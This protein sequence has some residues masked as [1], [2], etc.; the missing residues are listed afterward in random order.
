LGHAGASENG[1][2]CFLRGKVVARFDVAFTR[3]CAGG[4]QLALRTFRED[5]QAQ[6]D[7]RSCGVRN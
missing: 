3:R 4:D 2:L 1:D 7:E 5:R 6:L